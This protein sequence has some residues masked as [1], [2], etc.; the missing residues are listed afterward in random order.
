MSRTFLL[1]AGAICW[2]AV[3]VD[4][5]FHAATGDLLVPVIMGAVAA[6]WVGLRRHKLVEA[7]ATAA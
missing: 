5:A 7:L 4:A 6:G 3:A 2:T 1:V